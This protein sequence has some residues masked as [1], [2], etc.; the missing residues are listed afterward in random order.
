[1]I[2]KKRPKVLMS[3]INFSNAGTQIDKINRHL[4]FKINVIP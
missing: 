3:L 4:C 2:K 1:M